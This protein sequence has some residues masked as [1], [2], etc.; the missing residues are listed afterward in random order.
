[1]AKLDQSSYH[2]CVIVVVRQSHPA[3]SYRE[4][5][6][7]TGTTHRSAAQVG[8][9]TIRDVLVPKIIGR[10]IIHYTYCD[11]ALFIPVGKHDDLIITRILIIN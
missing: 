5:Q 9:V 8:S 2:R 1:M 3:Q 10:Y 4:L 6:E 11:V 7:A